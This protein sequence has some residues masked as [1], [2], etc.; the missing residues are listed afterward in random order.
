MSAMKNRP[1]HNGLDRAKRKYKRL[2]SRGARR[3]TLERLSARIVRLSTDYHRRITTWR[4]LV[5]AA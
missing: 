1:K 3:R 2:S 5:A 4:E